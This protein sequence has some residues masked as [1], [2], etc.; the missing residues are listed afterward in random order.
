MHSGLLLSIYHCTRKD[1]DGVPVFE[2]RDVVRGRIEVLHERFDRLHANVLLAVLRREAVGFVDE[3]H[4]AAGFLYLY[5]EM[6]MQQNTATTDRGQNEGSMQDRRTPPSLAVWLVV[7]G[8]EGGRTGVYAL[9]L[10]DHGT[11]FFVFGPVWPTYWSMRSGRCTS[12][13]LSTPIMPA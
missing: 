3:E 5:E 12:T 11:F 6:K 10:R 4:A 2:Q 13:S 9:L 8:A 1:H 7:L